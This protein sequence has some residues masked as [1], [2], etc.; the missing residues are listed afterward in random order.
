MYV[1]PVL[2]ASLPELV[3]I[4]SVVL[5]RPE[6]HATV[7]SSLDHMLCDPIDPLIG[8]IGLAEQGLE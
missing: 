1:A 8:L 2:F 4:E 6:D 3:E 5:F 7:V